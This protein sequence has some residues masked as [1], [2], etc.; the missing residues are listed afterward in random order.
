MDKEL[1]E[2]QLYQI[3]DQFSEREMTPKQI[4]SIL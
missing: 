1:I 2:D 4:T 3:I